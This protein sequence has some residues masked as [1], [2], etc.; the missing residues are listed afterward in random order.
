MRSL[1]KKYLLPMVLAALAAYLFFN[2]YTQ[3]SVASF[4]WACSFGLVCLTSVTA[5][6]RNTALT[7]ISL[8]VT[9]AIAESALGYLPTLLANKETTKSGGVKQE[10][11]YFSPTQTYN[12]QPIGI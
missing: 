2:A 10:A 3:R 6:F 5:I 1:T 9:L 7:L 8:L 11:A 4:L 12:T